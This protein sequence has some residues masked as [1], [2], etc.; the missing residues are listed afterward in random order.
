MIRD[1]GTMIWKEWRAVRASQGHFAG[2]PIELALTISIIAIIF[3]GQQDAEFLTSWMTAFYSTVFGAISIILAL[4]DAF[5]GERERHTLETL[6]ASRLADRA[7]LFG[8]IAALVSYGWSLALVYLFVGLLTINLTSADGLLFFR[9]II[10]FA[11]VLGSLFFTMLIAQVGVFVSLRASTVRQAQ[12]I[13][14]TGVMVIGLGS[15]FLIF[16]LIPNGETR[17]LRMMTE[18]GL[19]Q[20]VLAMIGGLV[21]LN[22]GLVLAGVQRFRRARLI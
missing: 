10:L 19:I 18:L 20:S 5:A 22:T 21:L 11:A 12:Q 2:G 16:E 15:L 4:G 8:K 13:M 17:L 6:L 9:P 14:S 7:I 1:V 3:A